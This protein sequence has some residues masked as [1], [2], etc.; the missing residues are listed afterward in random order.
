MRNAL[1]K[2]ARGEA[3]EKFLRLPWFA[4][5]LA[6]LKYRRAG[7]EPSYG[8][9]LK[10]LLEYGKV[11][12]QSV[13]VKKPFNEGTYTFHIKTF[14]DTLLR[15]APKPETLVIIGQH[16]WITDALAARRALCA[17]KATGLGRVPLDVQVGWLIEY[18]K[19][20]KQSET[21]EKSHGGRRGAWPIGMFWSSIRGNWTGKKSGTKLPP[22]QKARLDAVEWVRAKFE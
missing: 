11:P 19:P 15:R 17:K 8:E 2:A 20:V 7:G 4:A 13:K 3:E 5:A 18:G 10:W 16:K 22:A 1:Q 14:W 6:K 12:D 9:K 21:L